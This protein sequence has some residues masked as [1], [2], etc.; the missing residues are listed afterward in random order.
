MKLLFFFLT[1][2]VLNYYFQTAHTWPSNF[3]YEHFKSVEMW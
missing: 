2:Y 3:R 1:D